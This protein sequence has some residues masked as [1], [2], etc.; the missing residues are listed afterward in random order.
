MCSHTGGATPRTRP[1]RVNY[2]ITETGGVV[3]DVIAEVTSAA[4]RAVALGVAR[5]AILIDPTHDFG[6]KYSSRS[7]FVAPRK[8]ILLRPDGPS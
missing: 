8:K 2:G 4:E 5:D 7:Y 6:K 3:D 1:F